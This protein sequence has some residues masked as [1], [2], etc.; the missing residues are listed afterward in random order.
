MVQLQKEGSL[1]VA[2]PQLN[3]A[4]G[5]RVATLGSSCSVGATI[6]IRETDAQS[7]YFS[8]QRAFVDAKLGC[9]GKPVVVVAFKRIPDDVSFGRFQ[10]SIHF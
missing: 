1:E 3:S 6:L 8:K 7:F 9:R 5:R 4:Q 10:G 2:L